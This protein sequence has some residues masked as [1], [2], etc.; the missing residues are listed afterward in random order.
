M[1]ASWLWKMTQVK[2]LSWQCLKDP[3]TYLMIVVVT[4]A[5]GYFTDLNM[6]PSFLW[7]A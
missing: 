5:S 1:T 4:F 7:W 2:N 6:P 3:F